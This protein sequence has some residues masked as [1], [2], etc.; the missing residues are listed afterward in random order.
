MKSSDLFSARLCRSDVRKGSAFPGVQTSHRATPATSLKQNDAGGTAP[1]HYDILPERRSLSAHHCGTAARAFRA[2][3]CGV[4][5]ICVISSFAF[6]QT[7]L[8]HLDVDYSNQLPV[9]QTKEAWLARA[10]QLRQQILTSAGL[11]PMPEKTPLNAQIFGKVDK[12][13]YTLEKVY[14]ES[15][16]G[17]FVSGNLYR[18]KNVNGKAPAVLCPHGH[19]TY[20]R[21]E[22]QPLNSGSSRAASF[23][24][25]GY[26]SFIWDMV[27]YVDSTAIPHTF[28]SGHREGF[29]RETLWG[30][31][32][33]GLQLWNSIRAVDFLLSLPEV[34]AARLAVTGESGGGTQTF[35]LAAIDERIRVAAPVNMVSALMQGG[36][37]CE[38]APNLRIDTTNVEIA[39]LFAPRPLLLIAATGDWTKNVPRVEYPAI[40]AIYKL[41]DAED[42]V[43]VVQFDAPHNYHQPSREAVYGWF[44]HWL[45]GRAETAPIKERGISV[46]PLGELMV[47]QGRL[48]PT[49]EFN[50]TQLIESMIAAAKGRLRTATTAEQIKQQF[51]PALSGSLLATYPLAQQLAAHSDDAAG[52][53]WELKAH[54]QAESLTV[55]VRPAANSQR[56]VTLLVNST[57]DESLVQPLREQGQTVIRITRFTAPQPETPANIKFVTTYNRTTAARRVQDVLTALAFAHKQSNGQPVSLVATG[58][59]GLWALLA[60]GLAPSLQ[61]SIIDVNAFANT[62]DAAFI[63]KLPIPSLR[64]AGDFTTATALAGTTPLTLFN[65]GAAFDASAISNLYRAANQ[66]GALRVERRQ[67]TAAEIAAA[68]KQ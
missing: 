31:N 11:S 27:G 17:H 16:P 13:D 20:G 50:E 4:A 49:N 32:L 30:V 21:L 3:T 18:P 46:A 14:F 38:N 56:G 62:D 60:R 66:A 10:A 23:A 55:Q 63:A 65:T 42:N 5:F 67:L 6:A 64:R 41:F 22:N 34:D 37:V 47:F 28:A 58:E 40:R 68:L 36:S 54:A 35:L 45:Q 57:D 25:Q 15:L 12:G 29:T 26:V 61:L 44:A 1:V 39:A 43:Q 19:W 51:A 33:L 48:R 9:Y 24:K 8:R 7:T 2:L 53:N 59:A 52:R